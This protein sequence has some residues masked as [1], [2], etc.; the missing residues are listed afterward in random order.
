MI[1]KRWLYKLSKKDFSLT[2]NN[3]EITSKII[4]TTVYI[5][6]VF[7]LHMHNKF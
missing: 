1:K 5:M 2:F 6:L 3:L 4:R 7:L